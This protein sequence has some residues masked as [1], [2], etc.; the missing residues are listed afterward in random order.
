M[1]A[2]VGSRFGN[3]DEAIVSTLGT[4]R[5]QCCLAHVGVE[6]GDMPLGQNSVEQGK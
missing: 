1:V 5:S 2:R 6:I 4:L 3:V